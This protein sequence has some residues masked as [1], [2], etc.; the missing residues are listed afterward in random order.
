MIALILSA[1]G[2]LLSVILYITVLVVIGLVF[3]FGLC[4]GVFGLIKIC[5]FISEVLDD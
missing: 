3:V 1:F 4:T 2:F 5:D